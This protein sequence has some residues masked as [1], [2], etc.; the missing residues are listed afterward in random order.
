MSHRKRFATAPPGPAPPSPVGCSRRRAAHLLLPVRAAASRC[1][2]LGRASWRRSRCGGLSPS[3]SCC[4]APTGSFWANRIR[5]GRPS[6]AGGEPIDCGLVRGDRDRLVA[7][8]DL[9]RLGAAFAI[10]R[11]AAGIRG[12]AASAPHLIPAD[13]ALPASR[14]ARGS[15]CLLFAFALIADRRAGAAAARHRSAR[16]GLLVLASRAVGP[17]CW[18]GALERPLDPARIRQSG[19]C[20]SGASCSTHILLAFGSLGAATLVGVPVGILCYRV[21]ARP[22]RASSTASISS[23][24]SP[25]SRMFGL[26]IAPMAWIAANVPGAAAL[27]HRGH[28]RGA[29][30][31]GAVCLFAVAGGLQHGCRARQACRATPTTRRAAWA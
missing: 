17:C 8:A 25:R 10:A 22:R 5:C 7:H 18:S 28:R 26:L 11:G 24:P 20:C 6:A 3:L 13:N 29:G 31:G 27:G 23:R 15:G 4:S 2:K 16:I 12:R 30:A 1:D 14:P 19:R 21:P 9:S